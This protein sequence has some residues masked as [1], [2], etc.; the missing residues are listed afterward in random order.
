MILPAVVEDSTWD[1][2]SIS[3]ASTGTSL[4]DGLDAATLV[5]RG[6][7]GVAVVSL[8]E[9]SGITITNAATWALT[10]APIT[11]I[12]FATGTYTGS[13]RMVS[14]TGKVRKYVRIQLP[15]IPE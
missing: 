2:F 14:A 8:S 3:L 6:A 1:G 13:L 7:D 11:P 9:G 5:L 4:A 10:V 12:A 15:I